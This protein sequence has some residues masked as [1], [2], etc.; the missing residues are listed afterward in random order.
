MVEHIVVVDQQS[1]QAGVER[2]G[3]IKIG[4]FFLDVGVGDKVEVDGS[5]KVGTKLCI[6][7]YNTF[8]DAHILP[9]SGHQVRNGRGIGG[10]CR[11]LELGPGGG[12]AVEADHRYPK[13]K[14]CEFD[15]KIVFSRFLPHMFGQSQ[16]AFAVEQV[17][18]GHV[19]G[20]TTRQ[21]GDEALV[22]NGIAICIHKG[23][24]EELRNSYTCH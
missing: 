1:A 17:D 20:F 11:E 13:G 21:S 5:V 9:V 8:L 18:H 23:A 19:E 12:E 14:F 22:K 7:V 2:S 6:G 10:Q 16:A 4:K 24:E 3:V 15:H